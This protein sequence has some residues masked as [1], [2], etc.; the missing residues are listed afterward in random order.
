MAHSTFASMYITPS[1]PFG[2]PGMR[3]TLADNLRDWLH[4]NGYVHD[5]EHGVWVCWDKVARRSD[6][7]RDHAWVFLMMRTADVLDAEVV[8][9]ERDM[10]ATGAPLRVWAVLREGGPVSGAGSGSASS[11]ERAPRDLRTPLV[12]PLEGEGQ[13]T[14]LGAVDDEDNDGGWTEV[15]EATPGRDGGWLGEGDIWDEDRILFTIYA[16]NE[17]HALYL[18]ALDFTQKQSP[19][20]NPRNAPMPADYQVPVVELLEYLGFNEQSGCWDIAEATHRL[21]HIPLD[22]YRLLPSSVM[23]LNEEEAQQQQGSR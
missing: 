1:P 6:L 16:Y 23:T 10:R 3:W 11:G 2:Q 18:F 15:E 4:E 14:E 19:D 5:G 22:R 12:V 13:A 21:A 20:Q 17:L 8:R 9:L 7:Y